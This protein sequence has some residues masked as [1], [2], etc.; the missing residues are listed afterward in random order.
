MLNI[1]GDRADGLTQQ[2][3]KGILSLIKEFIT[4]LI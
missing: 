2:L 4:V 3:L 1:E